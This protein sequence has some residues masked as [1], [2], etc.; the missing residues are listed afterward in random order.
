MTTTNER[1]RERGKNANREIPFHQAVLPLPLPLP[2]PLS[3]PLPL[4]FSVSVSSFF[5]AIS[6]NVIVEG[7]TTKPCTRNKTWLDDLMA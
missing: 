6:I 1:R 2:L 4:R 5:F 7:K 3:L